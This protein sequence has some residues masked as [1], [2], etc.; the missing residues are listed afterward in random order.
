MSWLRR[1]TVTADVGDGFVALEATAHQPAL[2]MTAGK[3]AS[4]GPLSLPADLVVHAEASGAVVIAWHNRNVGFAP[5]ALHASLRA[6]ATAAGRARLVA[7][8]ELFRDGDVWRVWV[9]PLPRPTGVA[10]PED[11]VAPKAP[12]IAGI[13]IQRGE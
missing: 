12:N 4:N 2:E 5:T 13:P 9:G 1:P 8:G 11:S 7:S 3:G 10:A 6:Q